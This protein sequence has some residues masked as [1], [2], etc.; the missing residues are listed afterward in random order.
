VNLCNFLAEL[1]RRN[2]YKA[3]IGYAIVG[4]LL[5]ESTEKSLNAEILSTK[6]NQYG[7]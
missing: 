5:R 1:N 2:V 3:A 6:S 7:R 4:S